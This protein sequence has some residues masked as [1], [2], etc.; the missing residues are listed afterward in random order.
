MSKIQLVVGLMCYKLQ[1]CKTCAAGAASMEM[2]GFKREELLYHV[3][4]L[5]E[6]A[7]TYRMSWSRL[8]NKCSKVCKHNWTLHLKWDEF[9]FLWII[10]E[11]T[12]Q[13]TSE[14]KW[15]DSGV[16]RVDQSP[17]GS[18]CWGWRKCCFIPICPYCT[19]TANSLSLTIWWT[20]STAR[21]YTLLQSASDWSLTK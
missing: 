17:A 10:I 14:E 8:M 5:P 6:W 19:Q 20:S 18:G 3:L 2:S 7:T 11:P 1:C 9:R 15:V 4:H 12:E 21:A 16:W 13:Q